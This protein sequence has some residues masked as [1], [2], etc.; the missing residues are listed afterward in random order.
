MAHSH[1]ILQ[2]SVNLLTS[3]VYKYASNRWLPN[4]FITDIT[5]AK[6]INAYD[7]DLEHFCAPVVHPFP[8]ETITQYRKLDKNP[9][10]REVWQ[11]A[12][13]KEFGIMSQDD[14]KTVPKGVNCIFV[15][16]HN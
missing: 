9:V 10:T 12:C 15:M 14:N 4:D 16:N 6:L 1:I 8:G 13:G 5:T 7:V 11:Q 2:Q 3:T